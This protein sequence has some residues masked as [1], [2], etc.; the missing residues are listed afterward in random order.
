M[1]GLSDVTPASAVRWV[2]TRELPL[3]ISKLHSIMH[4]SWAKSISSTESSNHQ[5]KRQKIQSALHGME[6]PDCWFPC[7]TKFLQDLCQRRQ[8]Y[9]HICWIH[10]TNQHHQRTIPSWPSTILN[11]DS[12]FLKKERIQYKKNFSSLMNAELSTQRILKTP[13]MNNK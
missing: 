5:L 1:P 10:F 3:V 7:P 12:K 9:L 11:K 6:Q 13:A 2:T 8:F 4:T